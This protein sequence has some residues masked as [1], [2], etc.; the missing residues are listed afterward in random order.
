M[1]RRVF[2]ALSLVLAWSA[3]NLVGP[4]AWAKNPSPPRLAGV[5]GDNMVLQ[6]GIPAPVW[7]WANPGEK[8]TVSFRGQE[9]SA[10]AGQDGK[11]LVKLDKMEAGGPFELTVAGKGT[12][13]LKNVLVGEVWVCSG[14]SNMEFSL[15]GAHNAKEAIANSTN[16]MLRHFTLHKASAPVPQA[17]CNGKWE[18]SNPQNSPHF[19]AVGY[20]FGEKL[21]KDL[22]VPVGLIH[23]SWGGT[24][25]EAWTSLKAMESDPATKPIADSIRPRIESEKAAWQAYEEKAAAA[26]RLNQPLPATPNQPGPVPTALYNAMI[27]PV[28][29]YGIAGAIWYQ[30]ESNAGNAK[31]YQK[32]MPAMIKNWRDDWGQGDFP[33]FMVSLANFMARQQQPTDTGWA[34]LREAQAMTTENTPKV[35][36]AIAIDVGDDRDIHPRDKQTVGQRLALNAL[37]IAYGKNIVYSG[38]VYEG[39]KVVDGKARLSFKH[40]GSGLVAKGGKLTGFAVAGEDKKFVWADAVVDGETIVVSSPN[41]AQPAAVRYAWADNPECNLYNQEGL[42]AVPFRTDN[43]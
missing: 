14:Q 8:I 37:A 39:M 17:D 16:P 28:I 2:L 13:T 6:R 23:T 24:A 31:L 42:P 40:V 19:T 27:A 25:I 34:R 22:K 12:C 32:Q 20:F 29:P 1:T 15:G 11:W 38:P 21:Q 18:E 5:F 7:G 35:G 43:W 3:V 4:A 33:F 36:V 41:V 26:R 30:G 9:K 10:T